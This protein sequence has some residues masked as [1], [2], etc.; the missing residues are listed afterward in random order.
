MKNTE[1]K[2]FTL[3]EY[4]KL[5]K[6]EQTDKNKTLVYLYATDRDDQF[7]YIEAARAKGYDVLLMD[8][9]LD[10]HWLNHMETKLKDSRFARVDSD[11]VDKL[12]DKEEA[13]ESNLTAEQQADLTPVFQA[14]LPGQEMNYFVSYESLSEDASPVMITQSEFM[15]RMKDMQELS[16]QASMYGNLPDSYNMVINSNHRLVNRIAEGTEKKLGKK[17]EELRAQ[18]QSLSDEKQLLEKAREGKK[19]E[20]VPQGEKDQMEE[21]NKKLNELEEKRLD[22]L[23]KHGKAQKLVKQLID[24]ARLANNQLR[25]EELAAFVKRSVELIK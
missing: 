5:I 4:E 13:R 23:K 7:S 12:I 18:K 21:V 10:T 2:Y 17:L 8:G 1:G 3:E 11:I 25:G 6:K 24:L 16:G 20:E 14:H 15:R 19:E 22:M 9:Q